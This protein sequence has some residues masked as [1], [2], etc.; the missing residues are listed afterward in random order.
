MKQQDN[1][2]PQ[3][4][5]LRASE[6]TPDVFRPFFL[7]ERVVPSGPPFSHL[8]LTLRQDWPSTALRA[9]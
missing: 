6:G 7:E 9:R 2:E 1:T 8:D 5:P 3:V 4:K